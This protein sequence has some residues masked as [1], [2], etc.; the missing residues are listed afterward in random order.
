M[1]LSSLYARFTY[2]VGTRN[3]IKLLSE[4]KRYVRTIVCTEVPS[5]SDNDRS[6]NC[7]IIAND[8]NV[9]FVGMLQVD[10][11]ER[12]ES[13]R[14]DYY[15]HDYSE[16]KINEVVLDVLDNMLRR[17][18]VAC[19]TDVYEEYVKDWGR[20][21]RYLRIKYLKVDY[22][23]DG[24]VVVIID[25]VMNLYPPTGLLGTLMRYGRLD[26]RILRSM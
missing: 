18:E 17:E 2:R 16:D 10:K 7:L 24:E 5:F 20:T 26:F 14:L 6:Y 4:L 11:G 21:I 3:A 1:V 13:W 25:P 9:V 19:I 15:K 12:M 8:S 22:V 23:I